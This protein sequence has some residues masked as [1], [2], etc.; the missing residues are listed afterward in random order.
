[1]TEERFGSETANQMKAERY[2][3]EQHVRLAAGSDPSW[4]PH[5]KRRLNRAPGKAG[6]WRAWRKVQQTRTYSWFGILGAS[7]PAKEDVPVIDR[8]LLLFLEKSQCCEALD[9]ETVYGNPGVLGWTFT[10]S[11]E[12]NGSPGF[13]RPLRGEKP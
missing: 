6:N 2:Q 11:D 8:L 12:N 9:P 13:C 5:R 4:L 10:S 7:S 1:M 3:V